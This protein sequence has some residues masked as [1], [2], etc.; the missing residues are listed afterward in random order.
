MKIYDELS[1]KMIVRASK[2]CSI[3]LRHSCS[4]PER[5]HVFSAEGL[6]QS[7]A[8]LERKLHMPTLAFS[9]DKGVGTGLVDTMRLVATTSEAAYSKA[10]GITCPRKRLDLSPNRLFSSLLS[11][12]YYGSAEFFQ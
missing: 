3:P 2:L 9:A 5:L 8:R 11:E 10:A 6:E 1:Y 7:R 12:R 4:I